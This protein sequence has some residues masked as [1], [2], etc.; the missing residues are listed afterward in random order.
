MSRGCVKIRFWGV[1]GS[2]PTPVPDRLVFGGNTA[3][4]EARLPDG[5]IL[6]FDAGSGLRELGQQL[7]QEFPADMPFLHIFLSHYHWD[8]LQGIPF[9]APL[10][11]EDCQIALYGQNGLETAVRLQMEPP[12]FPVDFGAIRARCLFRKVA[13]EMQFGTSTLR[14]F[15]LH[16]PQG[17]LGF[18]LDC[19][20]KT[21]VYASDHEHGVSDL[22]SRIME[23]VQGADLLVFDAQYTPEEY[24]QR[25]GWGHSSWLEATRLA[26]QSGVGHLVL[27]HHDPEH[28][29]EFMSSMLQD[30]RK[31]FPRTDIAR[32]GWVLRL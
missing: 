6:I 19:E 17:S 23:Q 5:T 14:S 1:R 20:G 11:R 26:Q 2:I 12:H 15:P 9:F 24:A 21:F 18:R 4:V 8:H 16:H 29:D 32:E 30:A 25:Q 10:F 3:C 28:S 7:C 22:D 31:S 13:A 27:F